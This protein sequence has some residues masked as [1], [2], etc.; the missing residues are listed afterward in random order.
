MLDL[1]H[2]TIKV[3]FT[4]ICNALNIKDLKPDHMFNL[5]CNVSCYS[6]LFKRIIKP[7]LVFVYGKYCDFNNSRFI[8]F[9]YVF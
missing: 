6:N 1:I 7:E 5:T 4:N 9:S 8:L 3:I 2:K